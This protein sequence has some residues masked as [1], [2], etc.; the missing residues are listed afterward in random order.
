MPQF[1]CAACGAGLYSAAAA[2]DLIDPRCPSCGSRS[3]RGRRPDLGDPH[4]SR[5]RSHRATR[6]RSSDPRHQRIVE[7]FARF[8]ARSNP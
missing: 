2:S 7:G 5:A 4:A 3:D 1:K 8:M 6:T